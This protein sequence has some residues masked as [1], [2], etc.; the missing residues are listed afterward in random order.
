[1][2]I[3]RP[4]TLLLPTPRSAR[5]LA[6]SFH[7]SRLDRDP[8]AALDPSLP[9]DGYRLTLDGAGVRLAAGGDGGARSA[10][11]TLDQIRRLP[12]DAPG[13]LPAVEIED[14][15][16][17]A[18]RG[19]MLD[20]SRCRIPTMD[21]FGRAIAALA[22]L[23]SNHLQLYTEHAFAYR[24]HGA[25]WRGSDPITH[26]QARTL[27]DRCRA[28]GIELAPNQNCFGHLSRWLRTPGYEHLAETHGDW[29]FAGMPRSGPFSLCPVDPGALPFVESLLDE[30]LPCFAS[31][32]VNIGCDETYDIGQGRSRDAVEREGKAAVYG[33]FVGA[34]CRAALERGRTPMFW[35]D[36]A[37]EHPHAIDHLPPEA[38]ALVWGYEPTHDFAAEGASYRDRGMRWWACPGTSSWRSFAGRPSERRG[39]IRR[40]AREAVLGGA[41]GVL[42][43]DWGDLGHRQV[44]PVALLGIAE[45]LD[46]AWTGGERGPD[47][48]EGVSLQIFGD[49]SRSIAGWLEELGDADEPIR[50]IA[51][52][53]RQDGTPTRLLNA[54]ALFTE[55]HPPP[56][57]LGLP[58]EPTPWHEARARI[59]SLGESVPT[60]AG[61]LVEREL[62]HA[63]RCSLFAC[64]VA[65]LR[66]GAGG[67]A[68]ALAREREAI[69]N[70]Q[71]TLW[72]ERSRPGGLEESLASWDAIDLPAVPR[73]DHA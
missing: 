7:R 40:G 2:T 8:P 68:S 26:D 61:P 1:M 15:P 56:L 70:E 31:P 5:P 9:P 65:L 23:K 13:H 28:H 32:R 41:E 62:R 48:L 59:A 46:A 18:C 36:I 66:R 14:A 16:A 73:K 60:G 45:G 24:D 53:P 47:F 54:S 30:L 52:H 38:V 39:N 69:K 10:R 21:E 34:I 3:P 25:V 37:R 43:T 20:L 51:G 71:R 63:V 17:V 12:T 67:D 50:S 57:R 64:G 35:G 27:D 72:L 11:A 22:G 6:G 49:R 33:R 4:Y 55:L 44:W 19:V 29:T 42:I 58:D